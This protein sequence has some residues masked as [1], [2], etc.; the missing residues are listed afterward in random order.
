[1]NRDCWENCA[2]G[3]C[4]EY[5]CDAIGIPPAPF[6]VYI[7]GPLSGDPGE[8][9]ANVAALSR[10]S[11]RLMAAGFCPVNPASDLVDGLASP[12]PLPVL[13]YQRRGL[14]LLRLLAP[15]VPAAALLITGEFRRDGRRSSGVA[16][17]ISEA[18]TLGIPMVRD[19]AALYELRRGA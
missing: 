1:M 12:E 8:Y 11:R 2:L 14:E 5:P 6:Y 9:L 10:V 17:E 15:F 7:A 18:A 13:C 16:R 4:P 19:E 3:A